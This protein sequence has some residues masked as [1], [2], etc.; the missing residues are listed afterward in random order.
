[1]PEINLRWSF[2]AVSFVVIAVALVLTKTIDARPSIRIPFTKISSPSDV[3][4]QLHR[5]ILRSPNQIHGIGYPKINRETEA[6]I[7]RAI[8]NLPEETRIIVGGNLN[9]SRSHDSVDLLYPQTLDHLLDQLQANTKVVLI[10]PSI[11]I[12]HRMGKNW[13]TE[14]EAESKKPIA[15]VI[16]G[17]I[18]QT[19]AGEDELSPKCYTSQRTIDSQTYDLG[20]LILRISRSAPQ[21]SEGQ[22]QV[23]DEMPLESILSYSLPAGHRE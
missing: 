20:C 9:V 13:L 4:D 11:F 1:M 5:E 16:L 8:V 22:F 7:G 6:I 15:S 23:E 10:L 21:N 17:E 14:Y 18:A 19:D 12:S 2:L 3:G